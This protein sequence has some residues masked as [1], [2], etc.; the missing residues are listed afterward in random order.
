MIKSVSIITNEV[1]DHLD[2]DDICFSII[3]QLEFL[4]VSLVCYA[5]TL[6]PTSNATNF[7]GLNGVGY[8]YWGI[9]G[10]HFNLQQPMLCQQRE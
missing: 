5:L 4:V 9:V 1:V 8:S 2:F 3:S 6:I 7:L 10:V